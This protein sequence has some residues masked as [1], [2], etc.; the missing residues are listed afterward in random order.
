MEGRVDRL[1]ERA[2][3]ERL[4]EARHALEQHV[5]AGE[6]TDQQSIHHVVLTDDAARDLSRHILHESGIRRGG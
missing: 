5:T 6:K 2:H 3:R 1:G 4:G